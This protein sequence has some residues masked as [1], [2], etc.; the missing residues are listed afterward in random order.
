MKNNSKKRYSLVF[1]LVSG[2]L[3]AT[4]FFDDDT[5]DV[6]AEPINDYLPALFLIAIALAYWALKPK[7]KP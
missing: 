3:Q 5:Q 1:V 7:P 4:E 6:P 2:M